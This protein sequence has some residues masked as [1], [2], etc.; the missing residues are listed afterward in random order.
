[1]G[2]GG[3]A[4]LARKPAGP[5]F[6]GGFGDFDSVPAV[7]ADQVLVVLFPALAAPVPGLAVLR[8]Q[9]VQFALV[10][11][12]LQEPVDGCE[13]DCFPA[14]VQRGMQLLGT[15]ETCGLCQQLFKG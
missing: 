15:A 14:P 1:M 8:A 3:E 10:C 12:I 11:H 4:V 13:S 2:D 7:P 9:D 5:L 6:N